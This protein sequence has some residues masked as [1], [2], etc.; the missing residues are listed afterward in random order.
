MLKTLNRIL[1]IEDEPDIQEITKSALELVGG[2]TVET[3]NNGFDGIVKAQ[4]FMPDLILLDMMMPGMNGITTFEEIQKIESIRHIPVIFMTA[5][6][7]PHELVTYI[8]L[9]AIDVISKPFDPMQL[10]NQVSQI[11]EK[12]NG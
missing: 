9:G 6:V 5:K 1:L 12:Y 4:K 7:Q 10:S 3:S 11:W 2:F 8:S